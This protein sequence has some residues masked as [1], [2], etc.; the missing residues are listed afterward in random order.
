MTA[1]DRSQ[2]SKKALT[3]GG[4]PH[5]PLNFHPVA[6]RVPVFDT[7]EGADVAT[8]DRRS[9][10]GLRSRSPVAMRLAA[11]S[12][13]VRVAERRMPA[14]TIVERGLR[15]PTGPPAGRF[16]IGFIRGSGAKFSS[17][18]RS[19]RSMASCSGARSTARTLARLL[20]VPAWMFDRAACA[21]E[22]SFTS[23]PTVSPQALNALSSLL[24]QELKDTGIIESSGSERIQSLSR[25]ESGRDPW[26]GR[27]RHR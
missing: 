11:Y 10:S 22:V 17:M 23:V 21:S 2:H 14:S 4:R 25:P 9:W 1:P 5:L 24:D 20:E 6:T 26:R 3:R 16:S 18:T 27:R 12:A 7:P 13:G 15:T 19:T 8:S